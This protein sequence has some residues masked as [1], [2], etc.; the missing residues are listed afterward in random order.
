M[1]ETVLQ[2]EDCLDMEVPDGWVTDRYL[3]EGEEWCVA[4][5][6]GSE[7]KSLYIESKLVKK[8]MTDTFLFWRNEVPV[9]VTRHLRHGYYELEIVRDGAS[10]MSGMPLVTKVRGIKSKL[11]VVGYMIFAFW[12][13]KN[14]PGLLGF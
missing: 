13:F 8:S 14:L 2:D 12:V 11:M 10:V 6:S 5:S 9:H 3:F 1:G 4:Y 7:S